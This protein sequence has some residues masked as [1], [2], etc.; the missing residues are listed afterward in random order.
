MPGDLSDAARFP[1]SWICDSHQ[2]PGDEAGR[3]VESAV[4]FDHRLR[5]PVAVA[6]GLSHREATRPCFVTRVRVTVPPAAVRFG[7][8]SPDIAPIE[9]AKP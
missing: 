6:D 4:S 1:R 7:A 2:L 8:A 5:V 3:H 9:R